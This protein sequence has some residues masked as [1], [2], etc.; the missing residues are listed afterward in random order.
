MMSTKEETEKVLAEI[1]GTG[2]WIARNLIAQYPVMAE[3]EKFLMAMEI[4]RLSKIMNAL[5]QTLMDIE[6][7]PRILHKCELVEKMQ[8]LAIKGLVEIKEAAPETGNRP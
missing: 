2:R 7:A 4:Y 8:R 3:G 5:H 6:M 1:Y